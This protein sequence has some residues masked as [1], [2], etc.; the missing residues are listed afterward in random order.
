MPVN[1][2]QWEINLM[3][4]LA[5]VEANCLK[6]HRYL[7]NNSQGVVNKGDNMYSLMED[8]LKAMMNYRLAL[9]RRIDLLWKR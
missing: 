8:Q 5:E 6:L 9:K 4:E 7:N 2:D 1:T 3:F